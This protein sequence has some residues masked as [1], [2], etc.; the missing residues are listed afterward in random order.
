MTVAIILAALKKAGAWVVENW[1]L[2]LSVVAIAAV[3][4]LYDDWRDRGEL[5]EAERAARAGAEQT[6]NHWKAVAEE[7]AE[8]IRKLGEQTADYQALLDDALEVVGTIR[9]KYVK[10]PVEV[11]KVVHEA[12]DCQ[13]AV[14]D[15]GA[16]LARMAE[17]GGAP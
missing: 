6:A 16:V 7:Q 5:L 12:P 13:T 4:W 3:V 2:V 14:V 1:A 11:T 17:E 10:V 15:V 9:T 8:G